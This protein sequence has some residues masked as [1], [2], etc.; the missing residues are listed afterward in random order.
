MKVF[1][2]VDMVNILIMVKS[3]ELFYHCV[4]VLNEYD[5]KV[6]EEIFLQEY[7]KSN[8]VFFVGF[9]FEIKRFCCYRCLIHRL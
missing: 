4:Q 8:K 3:I 2:L 6:S 5:G 9:L 7:C 1:L